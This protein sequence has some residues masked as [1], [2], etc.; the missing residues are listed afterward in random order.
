MVLKP[1]FLTHASLS[2]LE[3]GKVFH[4]FSVQRSDKAMNELNQEEN[5][6]TAKQKAVVFS[7][8]SLWVSG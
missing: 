8:T 4:D 5:L 3:E 2:K 6:C 7:S 1:V